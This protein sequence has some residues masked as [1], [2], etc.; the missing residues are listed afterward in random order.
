MKTVGVLAVSLL[1]SAAAAAAGPILYV[2]DDAAAGGDGTG[3]ATALR[4]VADALSLA[5][6]DV[7]EIRVAQGRYTPDRAEADPAGTGDRN[8]TFQL[9]NGVT[10]TGGW[11]GPGEPD[12]DARDPSLYE[13]VLSGDLLGNDNPAFDAT[14]AENSYTV[15]TG[16]GTDASAVLDGFTISGGTASGPV[17][18]RNGGGILNVAGS[19][20]VL[21]CTITGNYA[22]TSG[23]GMYNESAAPVVSGCVISG[24]R[25]QNGH[26]GGMYNGVASSPTLVS[27]TVSGNES[28]AGRGAGIANADGSSPIVRDCV[29]SDNTS[30]LGGGGISNTAGSSPV[31]VGCTFSANM[32]TGLDTDGGGILNRQSASPLIVNCVFAG[33]VAEHNGGAIGNFDGCDPLIVNC[34]FLENSCSD[35][36]GAVR[37]GFECSPMLAGCTFAGNSA[38]EGGAF[39]AGSQDAGTTGHTLLSNCILWG[40]TAPIGPQI[41]L[42]GNFPADLTVASSDVQ[43]GPAAAHVQSGFTLTWGSGNLDADPGFAYP[44]SDWRL[45]PGSPCIDAGDDTAVPADSGDLDGDLDVAEPVPLD[46]GS[47]PRFFGPSVDMGAFERQS[48]RY[49]LDDDGQVGVTDLLIL[50]GAW[51]PCAGSCPPACA[52]DVNGDCDVNVTDLLAILGAWGSPR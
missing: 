39:S 14:H 4:F 2:D 27:C 1:W 18:L 25:A 43:G 24:N 13:T 30:L 34:A 49:D 50:L 47:E 41:A 10:L 23:G 11:A 48:S 22:R 38:V 6:G 36:G 32:T 52:G 7:S 40:N 37:A 44:G 16:S 9:E 28:L 29:L 46:L 51:G 20:T 21:G 19:P 3:W 26:G 8:A 12:P 45:G 42:A 15:V 17:G 33:N 35:R 5:Q 31:I